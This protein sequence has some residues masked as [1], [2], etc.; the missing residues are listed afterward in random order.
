MSNRAA[1]QLQLKQYEQCVHGCSLILDTCSPRHVKALWRRSQARLALG[2]VR[3]AERDLTTLLAV[4]PDNA[5]A[6]KALADL[7]G[8]SSAVKTS[9]NGGNSMSKGPS[10]EK[11]EKREQAAERTGRRKRGRSR[12]SRQN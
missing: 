8:G 7:R 1:C 4:E 2:N 12:T 3:G 5:K 10:S 6:V 11:E 9:G